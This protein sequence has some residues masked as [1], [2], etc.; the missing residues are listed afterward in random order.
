ML[1]ELIKEK[2][3]PQLLSREEMLEMLQKEEF[4]YI[5][6]AP[7]TLSFE[8]LPTTAP[9]FCG[10]NATL[11]PMIAHCTIGGKEFSFPFFAALPTAPGKHPFFIHINFRPDVPDRYMPTEELIDNGFAVLSFCYQNVTSDDGDF[12]NGLA[13]VLYEN[14]KRGLHDAG[15]IAMWAWAAQRVMDYAQ[16]RG[17]VL[18][19]SCGIVCGHSR[20]GKTALLTGASD[21]RFAFVYSN[22]SG[23]SGA[24]ISRGKRGESVD[25]ICNTFPYWFCE[26][27][28]QYRN[29]ED[30]MPFDQHFLIAASA[31]RYVMVGSAAEDIWA[32]P[33]AEML[34]CVAAAPAFRNGFVS[35]DRLPQIDDKFFE[36]DIGYHLRKGLH[37]FS[38]TDWLRLI[39]FVKAKRG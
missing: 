10:G 31:P 15:K 24:A 22:E 18:D 30:E 5:P 13:G 38:R 2:N 7:E 32:D 6:D 25:F 11:D 23:C 8:T 29:R 39:G 12:T 28:Q 35:E 26:Q 20:L 4:G 16:T 14:G 37:F 1:N 19:L 27:Y 9:N 17:D 21:E 34:A 36:G 33:D 3:L